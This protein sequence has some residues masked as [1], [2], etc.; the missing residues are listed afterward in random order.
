[1]QFDLFELI[2]LAKLDKPFSI[3]Q[4]E[5]TASQSTVPFPPLKGSVWAPYP[6]LFHACTGK[7]RPVIGFLEPR[8]FDE[9]CNL[10]PPST[11]HHSDIISSP[12][13][14]LK[15]EYVP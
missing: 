6:P 4:F 14:E 11:S 9:A 2:L 12:R 1:M 10:I 13:Q 8:G 7:L 3:E 5:A 15:G